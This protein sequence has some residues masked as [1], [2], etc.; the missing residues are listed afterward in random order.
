M[1]IKG[2]RVPYARRSVWYAII[3]M[4]VVIVIGFGLG[5]YTIY[6]LHNQVNGLATNVAA[7]QKGVGDLYATVHALAAKVAAGVAG[8]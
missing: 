5:G 2:K 1:A 8:H 7:L 3:A 6:H 4:A